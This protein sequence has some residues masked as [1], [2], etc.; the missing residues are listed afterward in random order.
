MWAVSVHA[1]RKNR[2]R[3]PLVSKETP[4]W[5]GEWGQK[6]TIALVTAVKPESKQKKV[7]HHLKCFLKEITSRTAA[8]SLVKHTP[9]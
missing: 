8:E 6:P 2:R 3:V 5:V 1:I 4:P 9:C 7:L